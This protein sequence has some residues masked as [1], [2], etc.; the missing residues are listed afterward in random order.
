MLKNL[1]EIIVLNLMQAIL[2]PEFIFAE[3]RLGIL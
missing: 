1:L 3:C 2:Q